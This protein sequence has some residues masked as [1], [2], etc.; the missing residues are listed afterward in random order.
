[1]GQYTVY[2]PGGG[3]MTVNAS[4][5]AAAVGNVGGGGSLT[6]PS[7]SPAPPAGGGGAAAPTAVGTVATAP[8]P[9]AGAPLFQTPNGPRT[10]DQMLQEL[11][12]VGWD[13]TGTIQDAYARTAGGT[14]TPMAAGSSS[15]GPSS[16][17]VDPTGVQA[18]LQALITGNQAAAAEAA[19]QYNTTFGLDQNKFA[20]SV[21]QY[22][23]TFGL[24]QQLQ[25]ANI[26]AQQAGLTGVF[27]GQPTL[28]ARQQEANI[29]A[30]QA[31]LTGM[32]QGQPTEAARQFNL[33]QGL[34]AIKLAADLQPNAF[35]QAQALY[36]L[37]QGGFT[38]LMAAAAGTGPAV[39]A[40]QAPTL[41]AA[42]T[43]SLG[44]LAGQTGAGSYTQ[45]QAQHWMNTLPTPNQVNWTALNQAGPGATDLV[46]KG[47]A[48]KWGLDEGSIKAI[49]Q[50]AMP[51]FQAPTLAGR[52]A[53]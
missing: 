28:A 43:Q 6:P 51:G 5:A 42:D 14:V 18:Y 53:P 45:D 38:P 44:W 23:Q 24:S 7:A 37:G 1:M 47:L 34:N 27:Q 2:L 11:V 15:G 49:A 52:V 30:Q 40:F 35:R 20:E 4:N 8:A 31:A 29:A 13:G 19:R 12:S 48:A 33:T 41:S 25:A 16:A 39:T 10:A 50:Q 22:N 46:T 21:R 17:A 32:Y 3:S 9:A 26:A 36:G